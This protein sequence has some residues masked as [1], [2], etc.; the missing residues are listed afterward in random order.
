MHKINANLKKYEDLFQ[1]EPWNGTVG[2]YL[3]K[4][5]LKNWEHTICI[6]YSKCNEMRDHLEANHYHIIDKN[7][8]AMLV[9]VTWR[10]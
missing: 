3:I 4:L 10:G 6:R 1:I 2:D 9:F 8:V 7:H 5:L